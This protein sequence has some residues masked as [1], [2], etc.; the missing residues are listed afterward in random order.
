MYFWLSNKGF[1]LGSRRGDRRVTSLKKREPLEEDS[2]LR[3][4][5][6]DL[7]KLNL[8]KVLKGDSLTFS[9]TIS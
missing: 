7:Y 8:S 2:I 5:S 6:V 4:I 1:S 9:Y 3:I